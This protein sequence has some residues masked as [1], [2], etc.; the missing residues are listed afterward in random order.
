MAKHRSS[1]KLPST[2]VVFANSLSWQGHEPLH[3]DDTVSVTRYEHGNKMLYS[4]TQK[5]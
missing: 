3:W 1:Y 4:G 2:E 5:M